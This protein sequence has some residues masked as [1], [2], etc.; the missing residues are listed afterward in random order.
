MSE[1]TVLTVFP[2]TVIGKASRRLAEQGRIPA[3]LYGMSRDAMSIE[4]ER[5][6]F[7]QFMSHHSAGS[8]LVEIQIDGEKKPVNAMIRE[9]QTS[10]VKGNILH[11]DFMAVSLNKPVHA[12]VAL[13]F[14]ND[15]AGVKAGGVLTID[16]HDLNIEAKPAEIPEMLDLDVSALEVGDSLHVRDVVAPKS[17]TLLDDP[18]AIIASVTPPTVAV[19]E[20]VATEAA[21]PEVIGAKSEEE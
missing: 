2:R 3:V 10:P 21:E 16:K 9:M 14:V 5:H 1:S 12:V 4:V 6:D 7:E 19:E 18:D 11:V 15:P 20:E 17:V 13:R 8:T